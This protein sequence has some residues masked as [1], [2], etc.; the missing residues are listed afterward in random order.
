M[1]V[2][3]HR[4]AKLCLISKSFLD[5]NPYADNAQYFI[6]LCAKASLFKNFLKTIL[7]GFQVMLTDHC[8]YAI[9]KGNK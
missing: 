9:D 7:T 2:V 6:V 4:T 8:H 5:P 3:M 1:G